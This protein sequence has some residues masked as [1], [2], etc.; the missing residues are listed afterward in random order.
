[1]Q[2]RGILEGILGILKLILERILELVF[3]RT[4]P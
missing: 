3:Y 1:M 4:T 2:S